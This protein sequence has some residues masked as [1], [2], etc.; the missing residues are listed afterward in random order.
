MTTPDDAHDDGHGDTGLVRIAR[1]LARLESVPNG[2]L[3]DIVARDC[4]CL[5]VSADDQPPRSNRQDLWMK[6]F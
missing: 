4:V 2:V 3:A 1:R 5:Q 6:I